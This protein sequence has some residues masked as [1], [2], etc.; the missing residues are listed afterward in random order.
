[1]SNALFFFYRTSSGSEASIVSNKLRPRFKSVDSRGQDSLEEIPASVRQRRE[2]IAA[3]TAKAKIEGGDIQ[4][5]DSPKTSRSLSP[6]GKRSAKSSPP[7]RSAFGSSV[8]QTCDAKPRVKPSVEKKSNTPVA[9]KGKSSTEMLKDRTASE[10]EAT[11]M[12]SRDRIDSKMVAGHV[13]KIAATEPRS[14][15]NGASEVAERLSKRAI[16]QSDSALPVDVDAVGLPYKSLEKNHLEDSCREFLDS[17]TDSCSESL[18]ITLE[19][20][21]NGSP[22]NVMSPTYSLF[23]S[24]RSIS[25]RHSSRHSSE[26]SLDGFYEIHERYESKLE[27]SELQTDSDAGLY[28]DL[29]SSDV[30]MSREPQIEEV[31]GHTF[32]SHISSRID[33]FVIRIC[34]LFDFSSSGIVISLLC[35]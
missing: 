10:L 23:E 2:R 6:V 9:R 12:S 30:S 26:K 19:R 31:S 17:M 16:D 15:A 33:C 5:R 24:R 34:W 3:R 13:R 21:R 14:K 35:I 7:A 28:T 4:R 8:S 29:T 11:K 18:E 22:I 32:V 25:S 20:S 27:Y 1:M